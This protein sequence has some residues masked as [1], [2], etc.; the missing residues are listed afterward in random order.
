MD[1]RE[2]AVVKTLLYADIFNYPLKKQEIFKFLIST[3]KTEKEIVNGAIKNL[4]SLVKSKKNYFFLPGR[5]NLPLIRKQRT[6]ESLKKL[7]K[8]KKIIK[9]I[10]IIPSI[11]FIGVSGALSM[12]N[13]DKDDDIDIFVITEK[14][15]VWTT[16]FL[17]AVLLS[18]M[19]VYRKR[20]SKLH[21]DKICLNMILGE[22]KMNFDKNSRNLYTAHEIAQ[23]L[24]VFDKNKTYEK[25]MENNLWIKNF[26][27]NFSVDA[28]FYFKKQNNIFDDIFNGLFKIIFMEKIL[29]FLQLKYMK[30]YITKETIGEG[31]LGFHP[32]DYKTYVLNSYREKIKKYKLANRS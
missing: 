16:R 15:L 21:K 13:S 32:F 12:K 25:F 14:N 28:P 2:K 18:V 3:E 31:F 11:K 26:L 10:S 23:L 1:S 7:R 24:P 8:A 4:K 30:K 9:I 20:N 27:P 5:D 19:G 17:L 29:K 6:K 22:D